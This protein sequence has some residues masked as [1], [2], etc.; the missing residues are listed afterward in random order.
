ML[1]LSRRNNEKIDFPSLGISVEVVRINGS[2]VR[3]GVSAPKE[4][5]VLR[6]EIAG[7][8]PIKTSPILVS[9]QALEQLRNEVNSAVMR[10]LMLQRHL[11]LGLVQDV[12][13]LV[14]DV[15][16]DLEA[17]DAAIRRVLNGGQASSPTS[18][19]VSLLRRR[20]LVVDDS[21]NE[22]T[23]MSGYLRSFNY[24][25]DIACDGI[26]AI[27]YLEGHEKPDFILLDMQMPRLDGAGTIAWIRSNPALDG[28]RVFAVS[29]SSAEETGVAIGSEGVDGWFTKPVQPN[30]LLAEMQKG[31]AVTA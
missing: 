23:L 3:L 25:V 28:V 30:L 19:G 13:I 14:D 26:E 16:H 24:E 2:T 11:D 5:Q 1:V 27:E 7:D 31:S 6:H 22:A 8:Q 4:V 12:D 17:L 21:C 9:R 15:M 10:L 29:G 20:V 18:S